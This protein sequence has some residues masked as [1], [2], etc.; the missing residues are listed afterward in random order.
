MEDCACR[1]VYP[2]LHQRTEMTMNVGLLARHRGHR[3]HSHT[4]SKCFSPNSATLI[5]LCVNL[6]F[7]AIISFSMWLFVS[8]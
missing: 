2:D 7:K 1:V 6:P 4:S 5:S 8:P 3:A